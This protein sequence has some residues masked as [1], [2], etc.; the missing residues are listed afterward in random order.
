MTVDKQEYLELLT[1][2][3][4]FFGE[5]WFKTECDRA[6]KF[7][8]PKNTHPLIFSWINT[9]YFLQ[10]TE[11]L[12]GLEVVPRNDMLNILMIGTCLRLIDKA[13]ICD[14]AGNILE[15]TV[16]ELFLKR[17]RSTEH[18]PSA[19]YELKVASAYLQK[20]YIVQFI[21][22][23]R[24]H[25][26]FLVKIN[27]NAVYVECKRIE[28]RLIEK[29]DGDTIHKLHSKVKNLLLANKVSILV[30]CTDSISNKDGWMEKAI[31]KLIGSNGASTIEKVGEY[32]FKILPPSPM[33]IFQGHDISTNVKKFYEEYWAPFLDKQMKEYSAE[34][35]NIVYENGGIKVTLG[36]APFQKLELECYFGVA[37]QSLPIL[38]LGIRKMLNKAYGQLPAGGNGVVYVECPPFVAT[39]EEINE[40]WRIVKKELNAISRINA[41]VMTAV[42]IGSN[43]IEHISNVIINNASSS[44]LPHDFS[45]VPLVDK[46]ELN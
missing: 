28:K 45:I 22:D 35:K 26:E 19:I 13:K 24:T 31:Q 30:I 11:L 20:G 46:F 3:K 16:K 9:D 12:P 41:L 15:E 40:F 14:L 21:D 44:Q 2:I 8:D 34:S 25:P 23:K 42:V 27:G 33:L 38:I 17:L 5:D 7:P 39:D 36:V 6:G 1:E 18:F 10:N 4:K 43:T 37:F 32:Y 29:V